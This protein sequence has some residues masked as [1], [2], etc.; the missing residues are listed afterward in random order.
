[1]NIVGVGDGVSVAGSG[2]MT[3]CVGLSVTNKVGIAVGVVSTTAV[4]NAGTQ[5]VA[6]M[7]KAASKKC[8]LFIMF[9]LPQSVNEE[10]QIGEQ[11]S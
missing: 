10:R 4:P 6:M 2:V 8:N 1:M 5:A 9:Y 7:A 11:A 3:A